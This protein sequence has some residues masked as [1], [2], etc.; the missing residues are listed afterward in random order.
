MKLS[1]PQCHQRQ[2]QGSSSN[3][4]PQTPRHGSLDDI[5][6]PSSPTNSTSPTSPTITHSVSPQHGGSCEKEEDSA[7]YY[8][9]S[10]G[11]TMSSHRASN[12]WR[13]MSGRIPFV[14]LST[15][16]SI[17]TGS[18]K[19]EAAVEG[20][21]QDGQAAVENAKPS[22]PRT[23]RLRI[24]SADP[25]CWRWP[26]R[27]A[28]V[29]RPEPATELHQN[30]PT[31][32]YGAFPALSMPASCLH[33]ALKHSSETEVD[34]IMAPERQVPVSGD[35]SDDTSPGRTDGLPSDAADTRPTW[36]LPAEAGV[37]QDAQDVCG[38]GDL[39]S[40]TCDG[41]SV[42]LRHLPAATREF[43]AHE[44]GSHTPI[45]GLRQSAKLFPIS[46]RRR[47]AER[48]RGATR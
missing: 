33:V 17:T 3:P 39:G 7:E 1:T 26:G 27:S 12:L 45:V 24:D 21:G 46:G 18:S 48:R 10:H 38:D 31:P 42:S 32:W 25:T 11:K 9:F 35:S 34:S 13:R 20:G 37:T 29:V 22:R 2:Q 5:I 4:I 19:K 40:G 36:E 44:A 41:T 28:D 16:S 15:S 14:R 43:Q 8:V 30:P 23:P 47:C 6:G